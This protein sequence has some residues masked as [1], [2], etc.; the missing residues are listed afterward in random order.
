MQSY[1]TTEGK[2]TPTRQFNNSQTLFLI[3]H[4]IR[5]KR[6]RILCLEHFKDLIKKKIR[7]LNQSHILELFKLLRINL[8]LQIYPKKSS[9]ATKL[10]SDSHQTQSG[11]TIQVQSRTLSGWTILQST[12]K[13]SSNAIRIKP[14]ISTYSQRERATELI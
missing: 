7:C 1:R 3:I 9:K 10:P 5:K 2:Y 6:K 4:S 11:S 12:P 14:Y 13:G 8:N